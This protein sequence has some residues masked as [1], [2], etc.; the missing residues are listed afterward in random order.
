[1]LSFPAASAAA[2][3]ATS[4]AAAA[5]FQAGEKKATPAGRQAAGEVQAI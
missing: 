3:A 1:M 2:P 4:E 5:V